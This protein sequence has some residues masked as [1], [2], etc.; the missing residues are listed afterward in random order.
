MKGLFIVVCLLVAIVA[1]EGNDFFAGRSQESIKKLMGWK[2]NPN[3]QLPVLEYDTPSAIPTSFDSRTQWPNCTSIGAIQN[4]AE[5][6]SC[7]AFGAVES[8]TDR[9]CIHKGVDTQLSF[10]D[11]VSCDT[12][13]DGCEGG[14][15]GTAFM[16]AKKVGIV[17][18]Q[19]YPYSI[20]TCPPAQQ[21]CLNFVNT[22]ACAN[23]CNDTSINWDNDKRKL[24][25]V[26][27]VARKNNGMETEIMTNGPI[28][29]CFTVYADFLNYTTGVYT[30]KSGDALGGHCIKLI[31]WGVDSGVDYWIAANSWTTYW[32]N[33]GFF[34]IKRGV[35]ECGIE[36]DTAAGLP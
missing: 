3:V 23:A 10:E 35:N 26:Y 6:G 7:W 18:A 21:P 24:E 13:D 4:Q 33:Q 17:S 34:W 9:F 15:A 14:D 31:G 12:N 27:S 22:P 1:A 25:K 11:V 2:K 29:A 19:C 28:E 36:E 8:I 32:G 16:Y 5:C 30:H 20:P